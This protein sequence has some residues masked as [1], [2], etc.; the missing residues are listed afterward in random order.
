MPEETTVWTGLEP[1][2]AKILLHRGINNP[3][4]RASQPS[5]RFHLSS[6]MQIYLLGLNYF[7]YNSLPTLHHWPRACQSMLMHALMTVATAAPM[8]FKD[9]R[10]RFHVDV[11]GVVERWLTVFADLPSPFHFLI[12]IIP[13]FP[14]LLYHPRLD[15]RTTSANK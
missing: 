8:T 7:P 13:T 3:Q 5:Y 10:E 9:K 6:V 1:S 14:K 2:I 15:S 11:Q 12:Y 4:K